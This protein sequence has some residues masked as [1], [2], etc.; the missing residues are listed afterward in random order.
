MAFGAVD[1]QKASVVTELGSACGADFIDSAP[2]PESILLR[3][4]H[5][6]S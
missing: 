3:T 2:A 6:A 5:E 1:M 4:E